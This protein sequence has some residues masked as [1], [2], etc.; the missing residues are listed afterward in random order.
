MHP[1]MAQIHPSLRS[2]FVVWI[3]SRSIAF[4]GIAKSLEIPW[5][6]DIQGPPLW[7]NF[8]NIVNTLSWGPAFIYIICELL[9]LFAFIVSYKFARK[10]LLPQ[11][12]EHATWLLALSPML[13]LI[14]PNSADLIGISAAIIAI[15][16]ASVGNF[17]ISAASIFAAL[18][19]MPESI[20]IIP[21]LAAISFTTKNEYGQRGYY[22][23]LVGLIGFILT[24]LGSIFWSDPSFISEGLHLRRQFFLSFFDLLPVVGAVTLSAIT[25]VAMY[26]TQ[27]WRWAFFIIPLFAPIFFSS[28]NDAWKIAALSLPVC[29]S[30]LSLL[31]EDFAFQ[32]ATLVAAALGSAWIAL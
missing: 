9:L 1:L 6:L 2:A 7:R 26:R 22:I 11:G 32:R 16:S 19:V 24:I 21:G 20:F 17:K 4:A 15:G 28:P 30:A 5:S 3:L 12:A 13:F 29:A 14:H 10:E 25:G 27:Q 23:P 31:S 8:A 18:L